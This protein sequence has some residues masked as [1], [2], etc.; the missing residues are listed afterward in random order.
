MLLHWPLIW[1]Y[2]YWGDIDGFR[3]AVRYSGGK[4][5]QCKWE[6]II[7]APF[8]EA[9]KAFIDDLSKPKPS[10][11][12]LDKHVQQLVPLFSCS[13]FEIPFR[14][15]SPHEAL[16]LSGLENDWKRT[17]LQDAEYLPDNLIRDMCGNS[18]NP[19]PVG[20]AL[21]KNSTLQQWIEENGVHHQ[22]D[23]TSLVASKHEAHAIYADL[24]SKVTSRF[25]KDHPNKQ[26]PIN[27]TLPEL[28]EFGSDPGSVEPPLIAD[29][30][31]PVN[32]RIKVT[33]EQRLLQHQSEAAA[34]VL[35]HAEGVALEIAELSWVFESLRAAVHVPFD[36]HSMIR[37]LWGFSPASCT[38]T[39]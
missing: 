26:L 1:N 21:G 35:T 7:P 13:T 12:K 10:A 16:K 22:R 9:W 25:A 8:E 33:K 31:L 23:Q 30:Q 27:R 29:R 34:R 19:S 18:F 38:L 24:V 17:N 11:E 2:S 14:V 32:R 36:F 39:M 20:S 6:R 15:V 5:P 37:I 28:P 3:N 4:I